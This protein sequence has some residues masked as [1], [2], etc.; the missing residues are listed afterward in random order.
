MPVLT[1]KPKE[2]APYSLKV[3]ETEITIGRSPSNTLALDDHCCSARHAVLFPAGG[4]MAIK[5]L[6]SKNGTAVNSR[7]VSGEVRLKKGDKIRVGDTTI[8]YGGESLTK[9]S[10]TVIPA[11]TVLHPPSTVVSIKQPKTPPAD[12]RDAQLIEAANQALYYD[13]PPNEFLDRIM[14]VVVEFVPMDRGI[15][16]IRDP[17]TGELRREV[18][19]VPDESRPLEDLVISESIIKLALKRNSSLFIPDVTKVEPISEAKSVVLLKIHSAMCV[20]MMHG[21][22]VIGIIYADRISV[23]EAFSESDL[24]DLTLLAG[25]AATRIREVR[26]RQQQDDRDRLNKQLDMARVM[27][28]DML[29]KQD[30]AFEP[31]DISGSAWPCHQVG[32]DY[33]NF[34]DLGTDRLGIVIADV[35]G[36]GLCSG[37]LMFYLSG[38]LLPEIEQASD[39]A[40]LTARLNN[41]VHRKSEPEAF[42]SFFIGILERGEESI[43]YAN[44][45]HNPPFLIDSHGRIRTLDGTGMCLGMLPSM[46]YETATAPFGPGDLLCLY[47]DG[48]TEAMNGRREQFGEE[49]LVAVIRENAGLPAKEIVARA[50]QAVAKFTGTPH[51]E[52]DMTLVILK[53]K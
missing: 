37:M 15:L 9:S 20:P 18:V 23:F 24:R 43:V 44:A 14:D 49:K 33:F 46:T 7:T 12:S 51:P 10:K 30:P 22:E 17:R 45:G 39:L 2:G 5:D 35:S 16:M 29:P 26:I 48:I 36:A 1:V 52:D 21:Q 34:V 42:I 27:Q 50:Y 25:V 53:R 41:H 28:Q 4:G 47:T 31:F 13:Q 11:E 8:I 6:G 3:E 40:D 32:G 19:K 38:L